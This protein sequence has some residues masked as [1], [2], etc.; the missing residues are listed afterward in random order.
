MLS[1]SKY[2]YRAGWLITLLRTY[3]KGSVGW[4]NSWR[5]YASKKPCLS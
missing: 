4:I 2:L 1:L 5:I 3:A